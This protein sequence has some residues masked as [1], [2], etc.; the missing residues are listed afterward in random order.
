MGCYSAWVCLDILPTGSN[1][2]T[3]VP[4]LASTQPTASNV[5]TAPFALFL[6]ICLQIW[7]ETPAVRRR[8]TSPELEDERENHNH[9]HTHTLLTLN[10]LGIYFLFLSS[11]DGSF[12]FATEIK[13]DNK[14]LYLTETFMKWTQSQTYCRDSHTDRTAG[15]H[16]R[17]E[18]LDDLHSWW[19]RHTK[20]TQKADSKQRLGVTWTNFIYKDMI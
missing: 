20:M 19:S 9:T 3:S 15:R 6:S 14:T 4:P 5:P 7:R 10:C 2:M 12:I 17:D 16:Q 18:D 11:A 1:M 13:K 8:R